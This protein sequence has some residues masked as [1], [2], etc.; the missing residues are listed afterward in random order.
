MLLLV[1]ELL[2]YYDLD[3]SANVF[4]NEANLLDPTDR[5]SLAQQTNTKKGEKKPLLV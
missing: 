3:Y 2:E 5:D 1:K 4:E